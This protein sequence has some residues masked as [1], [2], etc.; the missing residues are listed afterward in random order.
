LARELGPSR[1]P[2]HTLRQRLQAN[3]LA[4]A[5]TPVMAGTAFEADELYQNAGAKKHP[6]IAIPTTRHGDA[7]I[8]T[9]A[10]AP[11]P[12]IGPPA[13]ALWRATRAS[14]AYGWVTLQPCGRAVSA[15]PKPFRLVA[16]GWT[17]TTGRATGAVIQPMPRGDFDGEVFGRGEDLPMELQKP[18]PVHTRLAALRSGL[19]GVVTQDVAHGQFIDVVSQIRE[20]TL[21]PATARGRIVCS[22]L[23]H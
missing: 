14:N 6:P 17:P 22:H 13:S 16:R 10:M 11:L 4:T 23:D 1:E 21:E 12:T 20:R 7:P 5:P 18:R 15:S 2:L 3:L 9:K 19:Q 8:S